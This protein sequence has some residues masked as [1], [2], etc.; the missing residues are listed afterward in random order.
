MEL[1]QEACDKLLLDRVDAKLRGK[2]VSSITNRLRVAKPVKRDEEASFISVN[3]AISN[4]FFAI[5]L[6]RT[7]K[8]CPIYGVLA[9]WTLFR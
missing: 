4:W 2:K 1:R 7:M 9:I 6:P 3:H 5:A 8:F